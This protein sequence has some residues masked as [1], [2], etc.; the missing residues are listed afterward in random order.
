MS[1]LRLLQKKAQVGETMN[2]TN[3]DE[4]MKQQIIRLLDEE[5][6]F[7]VSDKKDYIL[8]IENVS[9]DDIDTITSIVN[10]VKN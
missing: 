4:R 5:L 9:K 6:D 7:T 3:I 10:S 1:I 8:T 2:I